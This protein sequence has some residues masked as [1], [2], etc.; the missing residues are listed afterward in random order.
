MN[1]AVEIAIVLTTV[2]SPEEAD[3]VAESL[4]RESLIACAQI[5]GPIVSHYEWD[6]KLERANEYR[7][8]LKTRLGVW[9]ALHRHLAEIHPYDEPEI[10]LLP[11]T[12]ASDGYRQWV[13]AQTTSAPG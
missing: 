10:L 11:V 6:G 12:D 7:L 4:L 9:P 1:Q 2:A 13:V 8:M 3:A 5:D